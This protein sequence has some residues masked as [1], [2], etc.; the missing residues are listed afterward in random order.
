MST[1]AFETITPDQA[2]N[3]QSGDYLT[4][5]QG[6]AS[7]AVVRYLPAAGGQPLRIEL[8]IDGRTVV[9]GEQLSD[10]TLR[11]A[12][13]IRDGSRVVIGNEGKQSIG[14]SPLGDALYGGE[15]DDVIHGGAG[16]DRIQGNQGNDTLYGDAGANTISGGQGDD[17]IYASTSMET[18][19]SWV[20]GNKGDDHIYGGGGPDTLL[21]GQGDDFIFGAGGN[22]YLSGDLGD[23]EIYSGSG[24]DTVL[25]GAG[26]DTLTSSDGSDLMMGGDG[27]DMIVAYGYGRATL[28]G[29]AGDD[30]IVAA[31]HGQSLLFGGAGH[32]RFEIVGFDKPNPQSDYI[33]GDW[34]HGDSLYFAQVHIHTVQPGEYSEINSDTYE[35]ALALANQQIANSGV[36]YVAAQ[37]GKDVI[38]FAET[39]GNLANGADAAVILTGRT[40]ADIDSTN[41]V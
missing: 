4:L 39:D 27:N 11:G 37:V 33:I 28:D 6:P 23:D 40:L 26:N 41:F 10:L 12:F 9:F 21:G 29:G 13:E 3:I 1:Y 24:D 35:H 34:E 19:G 2:L 16:D 38:V 30:T 7:R 18:V 22:D 25:G 17:V 5:A 31:T 8:T 15:G 36:R 20:N 32:D 14:G